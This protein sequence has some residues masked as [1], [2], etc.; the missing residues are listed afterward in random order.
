MQKCIEH[1]QVAFNISCFFFVVRIR[2]SINA[3]LHEFC[4]LCEKLES[5]RIRSYVEL[6]GSKAKSR[7]TAGRRK[8]DAIDGLA[9]GNENEAAVHFKYGFVDC[10]RLGLF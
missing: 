1:E 9:V 6:K 3:S 4:S 10:S 8:F 5:H 2:I 7:M